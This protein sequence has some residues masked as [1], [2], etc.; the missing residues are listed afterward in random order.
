MPITIRKAVPA[1]A[2]GI[3]RAHIDSWRTTYKGLI[4]DAVLQGLSCERRTERWRQDLSD[5]QNTDFA[6]V[7]ESE[8]GEILGF[9]S[10]GPERSGDPDY[11]GEV[12]AIYLVQPAQGQGIGRRLM[13][14]AAAE[15]L[16]RGY[17]SMLLWVLRDNTPSRKF[18]EAL[19][20]TSLREQT[21]EIGGREYLEVAYGWRDL[22]GLAGKANG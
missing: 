20:G 7:A 3:A 4:A 11:R 15:L 21:I 2:A 10:A 17:S 19:G 6:F 1:D 13:Q 14:A 18:Y 5:P 12:M 22:A 9:V 16:E 8:A